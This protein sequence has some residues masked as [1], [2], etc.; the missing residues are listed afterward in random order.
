VRA[1]LQQAVVGGQRQGVG[2]NAAAQVGEYRAWRAVYAGQQQ[3]VVV[4]ALDAGQGHRHPAAGAGLGAAD[5]H[6]VEAVADD[7]L[8]LP[9]EIG[10]QRREAVL[11]QPLRL[12]ANEFLIEVQ[13]A[14]FATGGQE[15]L[16]G[17][18]HLPD[19]AENLGEQRALRR[20]ENFRHRNDLF[21]REAQFAAHHA[22]RQGA[23]H[24]GRGDDDARLLLLQAGALFGKGREEIVEVQAQPAVVHAVVEIV[25]GAQEERH[26]LAGKE[27]VGQ[28][29]GEHAAGPDRL[30]AG[31]D[32]KQAALPGGAGRQANAETADARRE[33]AVGLALP[34]AGQQRLAF[35]A[36][37]VHRVELGHH[38]GLVHGR[39]L[40]ER[41]FGKGR[42]VRATAQ[43]ALRK[44]AD[45]AFLVGQQGG[46]VGEAQTRR[47]PVMPEG[48]EGNHKSP[49]WHRRML[50]L[51]PDCSCWRLRR[52]W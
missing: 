44:A 17:L 9:R 43:H 3:L 7:G 32:D 41:P 38:Q 21:R 2:D 13:R 52:V 49:S 34:G 36:G 47:A 1:A 33:V 22:E 37:R 40:G 39:P 46:A 31:A 23:Q 8:G 26:L 35:Q 6:V 50:T 45:L 4:A 19:L 12:D 11:V 18:V 10:N 51:L 30:L 16:G 25:V 42:E 20:F 14:V 28:H 48:G 27:P 24:L 15:T 29:F 5:Q